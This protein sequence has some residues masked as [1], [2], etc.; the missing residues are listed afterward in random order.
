MDN[1]LKVYPILNKDCIKKLRQKLEDDDD[2]FRQLT[3]NIEMGKNGGM[4]HIKLSP[5]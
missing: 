5:S 3:M 1:K 2:L 4:T